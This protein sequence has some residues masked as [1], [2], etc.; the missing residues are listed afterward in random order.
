[1]APMQSLVP[2][3]WARSLFRWTLMSGRRTTGPIPEH[4]LCCPESEKSAPDGVPKT[5]GFSNRLTKRTRTRIR[6]RKKTVRSKGTR[7]VKLGDLQKNLFVRHQ[8]NTDRAIALAELL[9]SGVQFKDLIEVTDFNEVANT[10]IDGRHRAEAYDLNGVTEV[11]VRVLEFDSEVEM[12][13]YAFRANAGGS[14]PPTQQDTEH[15]IMLLHERKQNPKQIGDLIGFPASLVRKY[16][17]MVQSK[18]ARQKMMDAVASITEGG[19]TVA[20]AVEK[21]GVDAEKLRAVL[22]GQRKKLKKGGVA[23]V[24]RNLT[25]AFRSQSQKNA[26]LMRRLQDWREDGEITQQNVRK[27]FAQIENHQRQVA[28]TTAEWRARFEANEKATRTNNKPTETV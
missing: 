21:H 14:L 20:K 13:G 8:L 6:T 9:E 18:V 23:E 12:I 25:K 19:L 22:T 5:A 3:N 10:I 7:T 26:A 1:M 4:A 2:T 11:K 17:E 16:V 15:T 28:K 24:Q 27:I